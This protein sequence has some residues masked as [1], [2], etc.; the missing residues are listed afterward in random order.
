MNARARRTRIAGRGAA[1]L[2]LLLAPLPALLLAVPVNADDDRADE[3]EGVDG[4]T[5]VV[6]GPRG[7][8]SPE[9][10]TGRYL[11]TAPPRDTLKGY[12]IRRTMPRSTVT[13][14]VTQLGEHV[15]P[16]KRLVA[17]LYA[18]K[19]DGSGNWACGE[20]RF[21]P[22]DRAITMPL[23][24][25]AGWSWQRPE[26]QDA[27][28]LYLVVENASQ[29]P[30]A[31]DKV[32]LVPEGTPY[33][34]DVWEQ[35]AVTNVDQ[36]DSSLSTEWVYA[37]ADDPQ[38][39]AEP[40]VSMSEA[41]PLPDGETAAV[42]LPLGRVSWF[43]LPVQL[44]DRLQLLVEAADGGSVA[45]AGFEARILSPVGGLLDEVDPT[46]DVPAPRSANLAAGP[47]M[48]S[49]IT[50]EVDPGNRY[51]DAEMSRYSH[52]TALAGAAGNYLVAV[53]AQRLSGSTVTSLPV[54]I[55]VQTNAHESFEGDDYTLPE[56]AGDLPALAPPSG[57]EPVPYEP[58][59]A[60]PAEP[61]PVGRSD[62][63]WA[64]IGG[65]GASAAMFG[66]LGLV[67]VRRRW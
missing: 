65:L 35:P 46:F 39:R 26:C 13:F 10:T 19:P 62:A 49:T 16:S 41:V 38:V 4:L 29:V 36:L 12:A 9:I 67:L 54:S 8:E 6:G 61:R 50:Y 7:A 27:E 32:Q 37:D 56:Y 21:D 58:G 43:W 53:Y 28:V 60:G 59:A 15:N 18:P 64:L 45:G 11:D 1:V 48:L 31:A 51:D 66:V 47:G 42:D 34:I 3:P 55:K 44:G 5:P 40:G 14:G 63:E 24:T 25:T 22:D 2:A 17:R 33:E 30:E 20:A 57:P 52:N 23:S